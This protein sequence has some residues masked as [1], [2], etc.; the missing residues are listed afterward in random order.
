VP[1]DWKVKGRYLRWFFKKALVGFLP[2]EIINKSKHGFGLPFG[3]WAREY[4]PLRERVEDRL[5]D[6]KKRDILQPAYID[7]VRGE[8]MTGHATYFGKMIWVM[9]TLEEWLQAERL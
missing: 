7:H 4:A 1:P 9:T 5:A 8:H 2:D 3:V 6:L